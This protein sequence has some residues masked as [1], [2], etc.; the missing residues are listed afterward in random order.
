MLTSGKSHA[1]CSRLD[2]ERPFDSG[3]VPAGRRSAY[4][5]STLS[6]SRWRY[7]RPSCW[8][9]LTHPAAPPGMEGHTNPNLAGRGPGRVQMRA[10]GNRTSTPQQVSA[11][12]PLLHRV[13]AFWAR[14]SSLLRSTGPRGVQPLSGMQSGGP[15]VTR[16]RKRERVGRRAWDGKQGLCGGTGAQL[17]P[18][19][20][21]EPGRCR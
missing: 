18:R 2:R 15:S 8:L 7:G 5:A 9:A 17:I 1:Y 20:S 3:K 19:S 16:R 11:K 13:G 4:P 12:R 10:T 14:K 6:S 21:L